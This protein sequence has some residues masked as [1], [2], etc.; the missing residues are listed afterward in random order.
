MILK[1]STFSNFTIFRQH[2]FCFVQKNIENI[3]FSKSKFDFSKIEYNLFAL[4]NFQVHSPSGVETRTI[5]F[6]N[7]LGFA[8]SP[9]FSRRSSHASC[10]RSVG[11]REPSPRCSTSDT[12]STTGN[13]STSVL[14]INFI[15][16]N[17]CYLETN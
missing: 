8:Q 4:S 5:S 14:E 9:I 13:H 7:P 17:T 11:A 6:L 1:F 2:I 15:H 3:K 10:T 16:K 12:L